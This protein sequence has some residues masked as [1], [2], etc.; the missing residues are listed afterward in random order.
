MM[1]TLEDVWEMAT[2][3]YDKKVAEM[4]QDALKFV[5]RTKTLSFSRLQRQFKIGIKITEKLYDR[6]LCDAAL[7]NNGNIVIFTK[8]M[9]T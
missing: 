3:G 2:T 8:P 9:L 1:S 5:L 6:L 4:Y 7:V